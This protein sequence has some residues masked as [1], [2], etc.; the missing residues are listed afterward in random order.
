MS[1]NLTINMNGGAPA[2][3]AQVSADGGVTRVQF[4]RPEQYADARFENEAVR[5]GVSDGGAYRMGAN[6]EPEAFGQV[7]A[8]TVQPPAFNEDPF[9]T[10]ISPWGS[11]ASQITPDTLLQFSEGATPISVR[12]A[13]TLGWVREDGPGRYVTTGR[14]K[15]EIAALMAQR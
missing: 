5:S 2:D 12:V 10:A 4:G 13:I 11:P 8:H 7:T 1:S 14:H 15:A 9:A 6:G 3:D